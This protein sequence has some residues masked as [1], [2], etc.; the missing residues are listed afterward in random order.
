MKRLLPAIM[1]IWGIWAAL[2]AGCA[3]DQRA[4][5]QAYRILVDLEEAAPEH[6]PGAPLSL[7]QAIRLANAL[8]ERLSIEGENYVQALAARQRAAAALLPTVDLFGNL[9]FRERANGGD[10]NGEGGGSQSK[11]RLFDAGVRGQYRLLT[12]LTDLRN[13]SAAEATI[14]QRRWLLLDL[15]EALL[16]ETVQAYYS[17]L[18]A[19]RLVQVLESSMEVQEERLRDIR[20]RQQVGF[21]RPLDVAQ[22]EAQAAQTQVSLLD[23]RNEVARARA[24]VTF[25]T[26]AEVSQSEFVDGFE[27]TGPTPTLA[28][29]E[30]LALIYRQ[31]LVAAE[32]AARAAR[33]T[34]EAEI[35]RYYPTV[36][37]NLDYF[38]TRDTVPT[39][40]DWTGLLTLNFPL[41]SAGRIAADVRDAWSRF[42]QAVLEYSL[43][44]R[45]IRRDL[46]TAYAD[47][48]ASQLRLVELERQ[49]AAA[50]EALRQ[51]EAAYA[52]GLGTNLERVTA[53]DALLMAQLGLAGE[54][55]NLK[56]AYLT[57]LRAAGVLTPNVTGVVVP[58]AAPEERTVPDSPFIVLPARAAAEEIHAEAR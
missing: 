49:V 21:A 57:A 23:A 53:Q 32:A 25:L 18:R 42:R 52:A 33:A 51:A 55:F 15:R 34:V 19:E 4:D 28:D 1:G 43:T 10:G 13:V 58:P 47:L 54:Q 31:D 30:A 3:T 24:A 48:V 27:I 22:I 44:R 50:A 9:T 14:E 11:T 5:V 7:E 29:L 6:P 12:G 8:N 2:L 20:G 40:R 41:F 35:G 37:L 38:L 36:T 46:E 26:G 39:D 56:V 16:L 45:A 17:V